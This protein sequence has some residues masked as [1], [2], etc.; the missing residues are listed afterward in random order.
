MSSR[1]NYRFLKPSKIP[2]EIKCR[3]CMEVLF[4]PMKLLCDH[5]FCHDCLKKL[6][7]KDTKC[8][9]CKADF[10]VLELVPDKGMIEIIEE[11]IVVCKFPQC[12]W[13]GMMKELREHEKNCMFSPVKCRKEVL[14][15]LPQYNKEDGFDNECVSLVTMLYKDHR[16]VME[17]IMMKGA[18]ENYVEGKNSKKSNGK[19]TLVPINQQKI[20]AFFTKKK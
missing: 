20:D 2:Q 13:N 3:I 17:E 1:R 16:K 7:D 4:N 6:S 5:V 14:D 12:D 8:P 9:I 11:L 18:N 10:M 19:K 15:K